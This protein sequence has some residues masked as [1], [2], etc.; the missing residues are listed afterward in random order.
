VVRV[1]VLAADPDLALFAAAPVFVAPAIPVRPKVGNAL[2]IT[3]ANRAVVNSPPLARPLEARGFRAARAQHPD[4]SGAR[5]A[6]R[7][8]FVGIELAGSCRAADRAV[9]LRLFQSRSRESENVV[10]NSWRCWFCLMFSGDRRPFESCCPRW[11][12]ASEHFP[13]R[14]SARPPDRSRWRWCAARWGHLAI[15]RDLPADS[16]RD[17]AGSTWCWR[18]GPGRPAT[19]PVRVGFFPLTVWR[20]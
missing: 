10:S 11:W 16:G 9:V 13:S 8:V 2:A 6:V 19:E 18:D 3:L 1:G 17:A 4:R 20:A 12:T 7:I 5:F 14:R 15:A